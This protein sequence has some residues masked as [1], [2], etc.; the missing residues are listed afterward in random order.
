MVDKGYFL[1]KQDFGD[2][3]FVRLCAGVA[4]SPFTTPSTLKY[5]QANRVA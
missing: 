1:P 5:F 2:I 3:P 4:A